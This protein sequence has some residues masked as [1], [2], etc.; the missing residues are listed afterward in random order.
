MKSNFE[1]ARHPDEKALRRAHLLQ[2]A[3]VLLNDG[4]DISSLSLNEIARRASMAK[5][6]TYRYFE[7]REALL[8]ALLWEEWQDWFKDF[9]EKPAQRMNLDTFVRHFASSIAKR[10]LLC[11][12]TAVLASV[13]EKN[14]SEDSII[15]F[16]SGALTFFEL[17]SEHF[18]KCC[19]ELNTVGHMHLLHD[20]VSLITGLYP[21]THPSPT[22]ARVLQAP[23]LKFFK[24]NFL[25]EFERLLIASARELKTSQGA[26][27][28]IGFPN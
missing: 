17:I 4:A 25:E 9:S 8:L 27:P 24:R 16:K 22:V 26:S 18:N 11:A 15:E 10:T 1:R 12:L 19:P 5:A 6:N 20:T 14:I 23:H 7:T 3:R 13:L 21:L 28:V 2:T